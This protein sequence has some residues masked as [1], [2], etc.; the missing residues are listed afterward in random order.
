LGYL[1][2]LT[3]EYEKSIQFSRRAIELAPNMKEAYINLISGYQSIGDSRRA[4]SVI[5]VYRSIR[6][7]DF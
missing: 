6:P 2:G 7:D 3:S 1:Y 4:D 5:A